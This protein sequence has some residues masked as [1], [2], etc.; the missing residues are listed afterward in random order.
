MAS[1][2]L[3]A[4]SVRPV[5]P[6]E[7]PLESYAKVMSLK[8]M[9]MQQKEGALDLQ[10]KQ[11]A[12]DEQK[13]IMQIYMDTGGDQEKT[14]QAAAQS[15]KVRPQT[16]NQMREGMFKAQQERQKLTTEQLTA[17]QKKTELYGQA[18]G[19]ILALP[20]EQRKQ[21]VSQAIPGLVQNGVIPEDE[22][23][24]LAGQLPQMDDASLEQFLKLHQ[25]SA[26]AADKQLSDA[27]AAKEQAV[28]LPGEQAD[29]DQKVRQNAA[30]QLASSKDQAD[31]E[32]RRNQL[33]FA[34]AKQFPDQFDKDSVLQA[35]MTPHEQAS[36][37]V[38]KL[39]LK[40]YM[41]KNP[42][43]GPADFARFKA[44]IAPTVRF[45]LESGGTTPK[46]PDGTTDVGAVAKKFGMTQ[47]AFDQQAEKYFL[48]GTLP[49]VGRGMSG[50]AFQRALMNRTAELHP[51]GDLAGNAAAFKANS[52]SLKKL[53][54]SFDQVSAFE[55]TALKNINLLQET[56]KKIPDLGS[57]FA[58]VPVRAI[59]GRMLGTEEMA[60][61][62]T[63]LNTAQTEAA[64]VLNSSN[65]SGV[66][67]DSARHELQDI[68][69]GNMSYKAMVASLNTLKQDMANRHQAYTEQ[70][71]DIQ[72]RL[73]TKKSGEE[74]VKPT[75]R[76]N[77][78]T[79]KIEAF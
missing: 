8:N 1:I 75:H 2:P 52:D 77:P 11:M 56:A 63:A 26:M 15:G 36:V 7:S 6:Q 24:K 5:Q 67:S 17:L 59:S 20:P 72:G 79:G 68:V 47:A 69:D 28:K 13:T 62:K 45:N 42:G 22:A 49:P 32:A 31:Y 12:A 44:S 25:V 3:A 43:K 40:D 34:V 57:R 76:Y 35:G 23:Q 10:Q 58:N 18:T 16:I 71:S 51:E 50:P 27:R 39:E 78:Q 66:L 38:E 33:P 74:Q 21:A 37:P 46:N 65:A 61:F 19:A 30:T 70:I 55:Q 54:T 53:Q 60:A 41:A 64:K 9:Q 73:K 48:S 29:A 4:L 14:L